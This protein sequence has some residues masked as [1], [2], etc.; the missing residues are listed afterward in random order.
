VI[1]SRGAFLRLMVTAA[2]AISLAGCA[3]LRPAPES[4]RLFVLEGTFDAAPVSDGAGRQSLLVP[5]PTARAG[6]D[7]SRIAYVTKAYELQFFAQS[8]WVDTPA[9]MVAPLLV[10]ALESAG[11][12]QTI[13]G[14]GGVSASLRLDTEITALQQEFA[15][16]PSRTRFGMRAQLVDVAGRRVVATRELEAVEAAPSDDPYG[17]VVAANVAVMRV[18]RELAEWTAAVSPR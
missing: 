13:H 14:S 11:G 8:E 9:R 3:L 5:T 7:G 16:V 12:F 2:W 18:L 4:P 17:G 15:S 1:E 10:E 6:Y